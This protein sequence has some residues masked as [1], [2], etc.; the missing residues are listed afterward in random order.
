MKSLTL[1]VFIFTLP[2]SS[3][4]AHT[5]AKSNQTKSDGIKMIREWK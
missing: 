2:M 1:V 5:G 4:F 3:V